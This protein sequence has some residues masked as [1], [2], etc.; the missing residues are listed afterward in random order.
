MKIRLLLQMIIILIITTIQ[1][2]CSKSSDDMKET[3]SGRV[4]EITDI[5]SA[6][7]SKRIKSVTVVLESGSKINVF[8]NHDENIVLGETVEVFRYQEH[9]NIYYLSR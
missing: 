5:K 7:N 9:Q 6:P 8:V 2:G 4:K 1:I 3:F